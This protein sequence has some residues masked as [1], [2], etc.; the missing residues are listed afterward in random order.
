MRAIVEWLHERFSIDDNRIYALGFSN[1]AIFCHKMARESNIFAAIA[2]VNGSWLA[3]QTIPSGAS[4]ISVLQ[5]T[6]L[7]DEIV[8]FNGGSPQGLSFQSVFA[9]MDGYAVHNGCPLA[10]KDTLE[11][12]PNVSVFHYL[13]CAVDLNLIIYRLNQKSHFLDD[14]TWSTVYS[15]IGSF[16]EGKTK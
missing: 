12:T 9:M 1:G 14:A 15:E 3:G 5:V 11:N 7:N 2:P 6:S 4:A 16:L 10:I 13:P 8:P